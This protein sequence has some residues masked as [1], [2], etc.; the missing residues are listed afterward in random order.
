V[1]GLVLPLIQLQIV[2]RALYL[3]GEVPIGT[4]DEH[5]RRGSMSPSDKCPA[6][7]YLLHD[8]NGG[9]DPTA[10]DPA[11]R[12][13]TQAEL[14]RYARDKKAERPGGLAARLPF[15]NRTCD[16]VGGAAW[17]GGWDRFQNQRFAHLYDGWINTDSMILDAR[18]PARC[19]VS[20]GR[21]V[22]GTYIVCAS[23]SLHHAVGHVG[24]VIGY[25]LAEWDPLDAE[26]WRA[27]DV[28][29]VAAYHDGVEASR[30]NRRT[31]GVGWFGTN[32]MFLRSTMS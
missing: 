28:V 16:C 22:S 1:R 17:C 18:G 29:N 10:S 21:P 30:A 6:I 23:G 11:D 12:W 8:H 4:L 24:V 15:V 31:T 9:K 32:A 25:G 7:Y 2:Q 19:F 27:I 3:A 14:D 5:V 26:C 20:I 13:S